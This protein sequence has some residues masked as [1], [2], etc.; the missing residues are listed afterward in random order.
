MTVRRIALELIESNPWQTRDHEDP[1]Q[2]A[3]VA[4]S[5]AQVDLLQYPVGRPYGEGAQLAFGHT[6]LA[7]YRKL[8]AERPGEFDTM[9]VDVRDLTD[10]QLFELGV[11]ENLER[12]DL[13]PIEEARA[14][15]RYRDDFHKTSE[16]IGELF[17]LSGG[18][19][20]GK[21]RLLQLPAPVQS[22]LEG[23]QIGE[24]TARKLLAVQRLAPQRVEALASDLV[25]GGYSTPEAVTEEIGAVLQEEAF[26]MVSRWDARKSGDDDEPDGKIRAGQ[27]LWP[28]GWK[29]PVNGPGHKKVQG[30]LAEKGWELSPEIVEAVCEALTTDSDAEGVG[31]LFAVVPSEAVTLAAQYVAPPPCSACEF[32][33]VLDGAHYCGIKACYLQKRHAWIE[34]ETRKVSKRLGIPVYDAAADGKDFIAAP[35]EFTTND[36]VQMHSSWK[37]L[38]EAKDASL[39]VRGKTPGYSKERGT[40]SYVVELVRVGKPAAEAKKREKHKRSSGGSFDYA[41]HERRM[42][43]ERKRQQASEQLIA[44]TAPILAEALVNHDSVAGLELIWGRLREYGDRTRLPEKKALRLAILREQIAASVLKDGISYDVRQKGPQATAKHLQGVATA[45]GVKLPKAWEEMAAALEASVSTE[46]AGGKKAA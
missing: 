8:A 10:V 46:T 13:T 16:E 12:K 21:L 6:R 2:V 11:R 32:H 17:H 18:A 34:A 29:A 24:G 30:I 33:Q 36:G 38:L 5:I 27:G 41:A 39:R 40:D 25:K 42:E 35:S 28:L 4:A 37:K 15:A 14:M 43:Q 23:G 1:E 20:R 44:Q 31:N 26:C 22:Q 19:V 3:E 45:L 9:P 7:A